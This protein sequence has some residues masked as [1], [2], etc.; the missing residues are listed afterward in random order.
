MRIL[1]CRLGLLS[2]FLCLFGLMQMKLL[3]AQ[4][5]ALEGLQ[6]S[7]V[8]ERKGEGGTSSFEL[9][10]EPGSA[11]RLQ[12]LTAQGVGK[13][14]VVSAG[15]VPLGAFRIRVPLAGDRAELSGSLDTQAVELLRRSNAFV[16]N[17][18]LE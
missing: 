7:S 18:R 15:E 8:H 6:V 17:V 1:V 9:V 5:S 16:V 4:E 2:A 13:S 3:H 12:K 10:F 14:L 11:A